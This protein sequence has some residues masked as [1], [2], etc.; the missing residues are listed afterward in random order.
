MCSSAYHLS[1]L[2]FYRDCVATALARNDADSTTAECTV[3]IHIASSCLQKALRRGELPFAHCAARLLLRQD[4]ER[5]WRRLCVCAFEDF[6]LSDLS[7]TARVV[8]VAANRGFRLVQGEERVLAHLIDLLCVTSKDRRLDDLYALGAAV[9]ADSA[10]PKVI[11]CAQPNIAPLVH[12]AS[13]LMATC[14]RPVPRRAFRAVSSEASVRALARMA[15]YGLVDAGLFELCAKGVRLSRCLLPLL[16]PPA[17]GATEAMGGLGTEA[18]TP[19]PAAPLI[20]G[21][22]AYAVDGFTRI[23]RAVLARLLV[24]EPSLQTLLA[25]VPAAKRLAVLHHLVFVAEGSLSSP[26]I[27]DPLSDALKSEAIACAGGLTRE[28]VVAGIALIGQ[29]L[30]TLHRLREHAMS[31]QEENLS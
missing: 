19:M 12:E 15:T 3:D 22:P 21:V 7:V 31:R 10:R 30:P 4:P 1:S 20:G 9:L 24:Q 5:L 17:I 25:N 13:R 16:L 18:P 11:E 28:A 26:V 23:G 27:S 8:A 29:L 6:G 14:E 2:S